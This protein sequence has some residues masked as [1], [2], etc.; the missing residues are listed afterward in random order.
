MGRDK[1][2]QW[3]YVLNQGDPGVLQATVDAWFDAVYEAV[4]DTTPPTVTVVPLDNAT[5]VA[6]DTNVVWTFNEAIRTSGITSD[7]F[8]LL[9]ADLATVAGALGYD[10]TAK[11]VTFNPTAALTAAETYTAIVTTGVKDLAGNALA[12]ASIT[13]FTVAA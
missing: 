1:D 6:A 13:T 8:M 9:D 3:Q 12:A 4:A 7:N 2:D 5:V 11:I 10:S